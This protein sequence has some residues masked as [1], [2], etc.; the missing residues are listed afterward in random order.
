MTNEALNTISAALREF[1]KG[2]SGPHESTWDKQE[3]YTRSPNYQWGLHEFHPN[4]QEFIDVLRETKPDTVTDVGC[5]SGLTGLQ[6]ALDGRFVVFH[7]FEGVGLRFVRHFLQAHG[8]HGTVIP[9]LV[10]PEEYDVG[11]PPP[12]SELVT[13]ID[14]MEHTGNH[15]GAL[16][17]L[18]S[19]GEVVAL[20]YPHV[21][22]K[23][24]YADVYDE[25]VDDEAIMWTVEKRHEIVRTYDTERRFL[26]FR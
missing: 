24:P 1:L 23:P 6:F 12:R 22:F 10:S 2:E 20:T 3:R 7:D 15:L 17:W 13:A 9:Y 18:K 21:G 11:R 4:V 14:V 25:W 5:A 8:L 16:R 19:L 26:V